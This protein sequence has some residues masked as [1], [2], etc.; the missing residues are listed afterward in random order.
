MVT[1]ASLG[2]CS[3]ANTAAVDAAWV[4]SMGGAACQDNSG[5]GQ[6]HW[7]L[8]GLAGT[9]TCGPG[10][11]QATSYWCRRDSD[12]SGVDNSNCNGQPQDLSYWAGGNS[13]SCQGTSGCPGSC[14]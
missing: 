7:C 11:Y 12:G 3:G 4:A 2:N 13:T 14:R 6:A 1:A 8:A 9:N 10:T 5:C